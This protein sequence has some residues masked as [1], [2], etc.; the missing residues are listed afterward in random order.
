MH[1]VTESTVHWL[2]LAALT[3]VGELVLQDRQAARTD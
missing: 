1:T 3:V 2:R